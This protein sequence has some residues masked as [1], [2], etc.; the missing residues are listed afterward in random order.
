MLWLV[1]SCSPVIIFAQT[2]IS[3]GNG[4]AKPDTPQ[5]STLP[6]L[7]PDAI[8]K[9]PQRLPDQQL[10]S[11]QQQPEMVLPPLE[12]LSPGKT[13]LA[14]A[15]KVKVK[16]ILL[17]G[18]TAFSDQQLS[19]ITAPY[20]HR[21]ITSEDLHSL[22]FKLTRYYIDQGYINSGAVMP[23][24]QIKDG[25]LHI[26]IIEGQ[27][28]AINVSGNDWLRSSY[29][30]RRIERDQG[31][32]LNFNY[33]QQRL[34]LLQQ[35]P[36]IE[37]I[38]AKIQPGLKPAE[39]VLNMR[40]KEARPY[41]MGLQ[42]ANDRSPSI[43]GFS[44]NIWL[45]HRNLTGFGDAL[46]FGY[47]RTEGLNDYS[48][49]YSLPLNAYDTRLKLYYQNSNSDV[50]ENPF[51]SVNIRSRSETIGAALSQPIFQTPEQTLSLA[52]NFEYR[53]SKTFL[54]GNAF[55]FSDG[56]PFEGKHAGESTVSVVRFSQDLLNRSLN[57][58]IAARSVF[59]VGIDAFDAT[60][61]KSAAADGQFFTW[62]GQFQWV[63]RLPL[64]NS[65]LVFRGDVQLASRP[66][67]PLEKFSVGGQHSV[68]G[69]REN[70]LVRDNGLATSLEWRIPVFRIPIPGL[71]KSA[72]D[73]MVQ[74]A[75]FGDFGWSKN[76]HKPSPNPRTISSAGLGIRWN[77]SPKLHSELYWGKAF[78]NIN[79]QSEHDLQD[80]GI[81]FLVS[82]QVF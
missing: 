41:Q 73:G 21:I 71:S 54:D 68:R 56:V 60:L 63:R 22:R 78:R 2:P 28:V 59:S 19:T 35:D 17:S 23:N 80:S 47:G 20:E 79:Q 69:Y 5:F 4:L 64:W 67:L 18:N 1:L 32:P 58:V 13:P 8:S 66:L 62:L 74:L 27:L 53:R 29:I 12:R 55:S 3:T 7:P 11:P 15:L 57:Q 50:I 34:Q 36:L 77:P 81:H 10:D 61:N 40:I 42:V 43:G 49:S 24:Q 26:N 45:V 76:D 65:Q 33:L 52:L 30:K 70:Q 75:V 9:Q 16:K 37:R 72:D 38:N 82:Y 51:A 46:T 31:P 6:F 39:S 48:G 25:I 14:K 44:G